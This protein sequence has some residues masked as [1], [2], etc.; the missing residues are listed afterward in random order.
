MT[1]DHAPGTLA[2]YNIVYCPE[3]CLLSMEYGAW[4]TAYISQS[5]AD[6]NGLTNT[7]LSMYTPYDRRHGD[8]RSDR[9]NKGD[10]N[11]P[12]I[13]IYTLFYGKR[14]VFGRSFVDTYYCAA[15]LFFF[16]HKGCY[17]K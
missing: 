15:A 7:L 1:V 14:R 5:G 8:A 11:R 2:A 6:Y 3:H 16:L 10:M 4:S 9:T 17:T 12:P 13:S